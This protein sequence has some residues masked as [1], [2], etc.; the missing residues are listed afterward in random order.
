MTTCI[1]DYRNHTGKDFCP[2][3]RKALFEGKNISTFL[4]FD[5]PKDLRNEAFFQ[6]IQR[7]SIS[8]VQTKYSLKLKK[9]ELVLTENQGEYLLKPIPNG[10]FLNL[11]AT[12]EN[13]HLT[14]QIAR[15]IFKINTAANTLIY[16]KD[17]SMGYLTKRFDRQTEGKKYRQEDFAQIRQMSRETHGEN[18]K[19]QGSY[20]EMA[21]DIKRYVSAYQPVMEDFFR[22]IIFNY[23]FSNG[24]A[25]LKN[26]SLL[27]TSYGDFALSPAYDLLCT[28]LHTPNEYAMALDLFTDDYFTETYNILG[29]YS[30][31][32][33]IEFGKRIGIQPTRIQRII[34]FFCSQSTKVEKMIERSFLSSE[35]KG[36]YLAKYRDRLKGLGYLLKTDNF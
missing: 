6:N 31:Q 4:S 27:E 14:M 23:L 21:M 26:F 1:G 8:G 5:P 2:Y 3:C 22:I 29:Y 36:I 15:Q 10:L 9:N 24:D 13:E 32:D 19:Y 12:P 30:Q 11:E 33:F 34:E 17:G 7:T 16:F 35:L 25:H 28:G 20:E 18:Y